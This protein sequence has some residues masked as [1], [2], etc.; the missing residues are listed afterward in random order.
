M[1]IAF[2][3][4]KLRCREIEI[5]KKKDILWIGTSKAADALSGYLNNLATDIS[6]SFISRPQSFEL[7]K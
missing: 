2:Y 4:G 7:V 6:W 3:K 1:M 5:L